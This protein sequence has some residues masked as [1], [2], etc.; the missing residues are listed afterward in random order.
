MRLGNDRVIG[1]LLIRNIDAESR[2]GKFAMSIA[3]NTILEEVVM[4][5]PL[6]LSGSK[7]RKNTVEED[8]GPSAVGFP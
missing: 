7:K 5:E 8:D 1:R 4:V 2:A 3:M 6:T